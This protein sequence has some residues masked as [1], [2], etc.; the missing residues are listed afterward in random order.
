MINFKSACRKRLCNKHYIYNGNW[1]LSTGY[2]YFFLQDSGSFSDHGRRSSK[3]ESSSNSP[4]FGISSRRY[5][6]YSYGFSSF[7][8]AVSAIL[9][10]TALAFAPLTVSMTCQFF[11]PRQKGR[12]ALS[13]AYP[14]IS[15]SRV[16]YRIFLSSSFVK[17]RLN[18]GVI[19]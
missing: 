9:Y 11:F 12:I 15:I 3:K 10:H 1:F 6:K 14:Y 13:A 8:F 16:M 18:S 19:T 17:E 7:A 5:L 2:D 4:C